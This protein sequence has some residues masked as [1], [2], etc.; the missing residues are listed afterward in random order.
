VFH[1]LGKARGRTGTLTF[2]PAG[3]PTRSRQIVAL[4][5]LS[6]VPSQ[7]VVVGHFTA[8]AVRPSAPRHVR[9]AR[10]GNT[11]V[12]NWSPALHAGSYALTVALSDGQRLA[13]FAAGDHRAM[14]VDAPAPG[15]GA[16][17]AVQGIGPDG[18]AGP[19]RIA[20]LNPSVAPARVRGITAARTRAGVLI[21]WRAVRR[22]VRYVVA[23]VVGGPGGAAYQEVAE[24]T[25]LRPS[26]ELATLGRGRTATITVKAMSADAKL[27]PAGREVYRAT[28]RNSA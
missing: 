20:R 23:I 7:T 18:N 1:L 12:V 25:H 16:R 21:R 10:R 28:K 17:V 24:L 15:L 8:P 6:S 5:A 26:V 14:V 22:A 9:V 19:S 4:I 3:A 11:L 13:L 2:T 27:G